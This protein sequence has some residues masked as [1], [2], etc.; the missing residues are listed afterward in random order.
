MQD[1]LPAE[2]TQQQKKVRS[3]PQEENLQ[4]NRQDMDQEQNV[5][6]NPML[7]NQ[8]NIHFHLIGDARSYCGK[9][10]GTAFSETNRT[11]AEN[12]SV[13]LFFGSDKDQPVF[14][15]S[16]DRNGNFVIEDLPPGFYTLVVEYGA[17]HSQRTPYIKVL[18]CQITQQNITLKDCYV[19]T[20]R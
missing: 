9:I 1:S 4:Y 3:A 11:I 2:H 19:T 15:T 6:L 10:T 18:P 16:C 7:T 13:L 20:R 12:A 14:R 5:D 17:G 8:Q